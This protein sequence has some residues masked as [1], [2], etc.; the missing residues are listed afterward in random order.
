LNPVERTALKNNSQAGGRDMKKLNLIL[1]C[2]ARN[3]DYEDVVKARTP[4]G[5]ATHQPIA[6]AALADLV[7]LS[8]GCGGF[9]V[10][11]EAHALSHE[12]QRYFGMFQVAG[13][14]GASHTDDY[15]L[16]IGIRNSHD[17]SFPF[18]GVM[19]SG[20]FVCD[21]LAFSG[22]VIVRRKH[23]R[24][25]MRDL[26]GL[27]DGMIGRLLDMR[28]HQSSRIEAYKTTEL[29]TERAQSLMIDAMRSDVVPASKLGKVL[30]EWEAPRHPEFREGRTV[31]RLFNAF[32]EIA[33]E[34]GQ[35]SDRPRQT[36]ALHGIC[37]SV[38][39]IGHMMA[40][41]VV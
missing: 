31:W 38:C 30:Q 13:H 27:V 1:H 18:G 34:R 25:I 28:V 17:K 8:V 12:A 3:V 9:S 14:D 5:T 40:Q 22:E 35:I 6:H 33:K 21:N 37:D 26:P 10:V 20:V 24:K 7:R 23:T 36:Q 16:V 19:G 11:E 15:S 41:E 39:G 2:G 29:S 32:T 4:E